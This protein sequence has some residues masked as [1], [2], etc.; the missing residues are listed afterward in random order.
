MPFSKAD[1]ARLVKLIVSLSVRMVEKTLTIYFPLVVD[2][3]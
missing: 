2:K 1:T 3:M